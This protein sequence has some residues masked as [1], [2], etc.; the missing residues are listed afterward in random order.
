MSFT[1]AHE[2]HAGH[3]AHHGHG[4]SGHMSDP[5]MQHMYMQH[6][7]R[8]WVHFAVIALG[9]WLLASPWMLGYLEPGSFGPDVGRVTAERGLAPPE[10]RAQ[11]MMW[12]DIAA[13][14]LL[15]VFGAMSLFWRHRWAQWGTCF[16]GIWLLFAPLVFWAPDAASTNNDLL[17]GALAI[18]FSILVPMMPGMSM[19]AMQAEEDIPPGWSYS[20]SSW[21]QRLP[22]IGL[23]LFSFFL[24]RHLTAYQLGHISA[25]WD[26]F[27]GDGTARIITS[28]VSKAWPV[29]DAGLGAVSYL[30]EALSGIMGDRRRWRT[31]PWMVGMFGVLVIPLGAVSIFFIIIQPIM[32]GTWC[33]LCLVTAAAM[34]LMLPYSFD[35]IV[36]M[37]QFLTRARREGKSVWQVFWHGGTIDGAGRDASPPLEPGRH[38]LTQLKE[39]ARSLPMGLT[40]SAAIGVWLMFTRATLGTEGTLANSDHLVGSL[41]FTFSIAAFAEVA[42]PLRA[43]NMLFGAWLVVAPWLLA[44]GSLYATVADMIAGAVLIALAIPR[45]PVRKHYAGW[46][47]YLVW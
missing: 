5:H 31:M 6:L 39:Q 14:C 3:A 10:A 19:E 13:G 35:E 46:D 16:T 38:H 8:L 28:D 26:P 20:P 40:V 29:A 43:I 47:R 4:E 32:I 18:T 9:V 1:S 27:F 2:S 15:M 41:V 42:R 22:I 11:A 7:Q 45:G 33:T 17:I 12:S 21:S 25:V 23:A 34:V 30:L 37:F 44:G 36:A 24:A